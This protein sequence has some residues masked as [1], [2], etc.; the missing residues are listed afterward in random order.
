[1][2]R[3]FITICLL[4]SASFLKAETIDLD[5]A[6]ELA[7]TL[8][9]RID[10]KRALA[11]HAQAV[12]EQANASGGFRA[13]STSFLAIVTGVDGGFYDK[14]EASCSVNCQPRDDI[15]DFAD[16]LSLWAKFQM[17]LVK[18]LTTF[19]RLENYQKAASHNILLKNEDITLQKDQIR[20]DVIRAYNGFLTARDSRYL[21]DATI[22]RLSA[23]LDLINAWLD[24]DN[25]KAK[26]IDKYALEAGMSILKRY[27]AEAVGLESIALAGL[28]VL[29]GIK[30]ADIKVADKRLKAA[31]L[32]TDELEDYVRYALKNRA[33]FKQL[34]AGLAARRALLEAQRSESKPIV[35]AGIIASIALAPNRDRLDNPH[36]YDPFNHAALSPLIGLN[37][38]WEGGVADAK[39]NQA[40]A[41]LNSVIHQ[42]S[43]ARQGV[44]FQV[45]EQYHTVQSKFAQMNAMKNAAK[46]SRRWMISA[47]TD[48]EAGLEEA[49]K[50][51]TAL[52]VYVL[53]YSDFLK[54]MNDYNISVS[55]LASVTGNYEGIQR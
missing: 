34:D 39:V 55:K 19:G 51:I 33:E 28:S 45:A 11:E 16:G 18:P 12:L 15:F 42:A 10:Q 8:D 29:T 53:A 41:E 6:I 48:F 44:P 26:L 37:W 38:A 40:K 21:M 43:F 9:P 31:E 14:G 36:I 24:E 35:F 52:Q 2:I 47:Y 46:S 3:L 27:K 32:P 17:T 20:L 5:K 4:L 30:T 7:L 23:A 50:I 49:E 25:G 22:K 54:I 13:N 1:M